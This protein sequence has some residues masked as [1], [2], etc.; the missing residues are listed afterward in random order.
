M[1]YLYEDC[2]WMD[3]L[4]LIAG[5]LS[6][7]PSL[8]HLFAK[9]TLV[10]SGRG[11]VTPSTSTSSII[12]H[13]HALD[14]APGSDRRHVSSLPSCPVSHLAALSSS[15]R[16]LFSHGANP[17]KPLRHFLGACVLLVSAEALSSH[18]VL[19]CQVLWLRHKSASLFLRNSVDVC[20]GTFTA[21]MTRKTT[22]NVFFFSGCLRDGYVLIL[23]IL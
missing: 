1:L 8:C 5:T 21:A 13:L 9:G 3:L 19:L 15:W 16:Q 6:V 10:Y 12:S 18:C 22:K 20:F 14:P 7:P 11:A 23:V 2:A 4:I 17:P